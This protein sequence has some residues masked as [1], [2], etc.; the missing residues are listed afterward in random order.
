VDVMIVPSK[1]EN[2]SN[3]IMEALACGTPVVGFNIGGNSDMIEHQNNG[4]LAKPFDP[5]DMAK[6]IDWVLREVQGSK[7]NI[8]GF[9]EDK[10]N[11]LEK[12][13]GGDFSFLP[14]MGQKARE[15]VLREFDSQVV[16]KKYIRFYEEILSRVRFG[17]NPL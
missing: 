10:K 4:Y 3:T 11:D 9:Q 14:E 5:Q 16:G 15:K 1:Q 7:L 2:L 13:I 17:R 12:Q 8:Q 6:G